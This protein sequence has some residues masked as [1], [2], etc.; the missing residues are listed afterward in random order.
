MFGKAALK[1]IFA[2]FNSTWKIIKKKKNVHSGAY[3]FVLIYNPP[4]TEF[5]GE[6][7]LLVNVYDDLPVK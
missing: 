3:N 4:N 1:Q 5:P 2:L 6:T 7:N